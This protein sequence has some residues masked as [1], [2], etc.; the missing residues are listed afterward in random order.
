MSLPHPLRTTLRRL[1]RTP[2]FTLVTVLTLA[3]GIGAT[4]S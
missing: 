2:L 3:I 4:V 1:A